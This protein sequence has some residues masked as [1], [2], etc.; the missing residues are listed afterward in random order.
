MELVTVHASSQGYP[1]S[2]EHQLSGI[3]QAVG[4]LH[5]HGVPHKNIIPVRLSVPLYRVGFDGSIPE[6]H[7][8][9]RRGESMFVGYRRLFPAS[10]NVTVS[11]G[12]TARSIHLQAV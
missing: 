2:H 12:A 7:S 3:F 1:Y 11:S 4:Y 8:H 5:K 9:R 10:R 6:Q